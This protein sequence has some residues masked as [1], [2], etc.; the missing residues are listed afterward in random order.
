VG[1][2]VVLSL[3][4]KT[5]C[6]T[7]DLKQTR[8]VHLLAAYL[9]QEGIVLFQMEV[10]LKEN[11]IP[12]AARLLKC[13]DLRGKIV[14]GDALLTQR[15]LCLQIVQGGGAYLFKVKANQPQLY[16][17]IQRLFTDVP[18]GADFQRAHTEEK[19]HG[20]LE[21]RTLTTSSLLK[22]SVEWPH[23]EQVF[24]L[25]RRV[26]VI[27]TGECSEETTYGITSLRSGEASP[28]RLLKVVRQHWAIENGL[29]YRRDVTFHEDHSRLRRG[30]APQAMA[31]LNNLVLSL[32]AWLGF[33]NAAE[34]RR[35]FA[36]HLREA[37][38]TLLQAPA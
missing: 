18:P 14:T 5:L 12:V 13:L 22:G 1:V 20:R 30:R 25:V 29:H 26:T 2:T 9:P 32:F 10:G 8:G 11:E 21:Q 35:H 3:D 4:G 24:Q 27:G 33:D 34:A 16:D 17:D 38:G 28:Q 15:K 31:A 19:T 7:I 6:G 23:L 37:R 36:A